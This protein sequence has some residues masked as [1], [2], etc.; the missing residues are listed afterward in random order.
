MEKHKLKIC[1][2]AEANGDHTYVQCGILRDFG[3]E[4]TLVSPN[5]GKCPDGV[6]H[7]ECSVDNPTSLMGKL[8]WLK[9]IYDGVRSVK[10]D[11]YHAHYAAELTTWMAWLLRKRPLVISCL[12]GDVLFDEQ[13]SQSALRRWMTKQALK[14]CD[15]VTVVSNFLGEAVVDFGVE[16]AKISRVIW[17][18][19][20]DIFKPLDGPSVFRVHY[21]ID[22]KAA[23]IFSPRQF[24]PFYNQHLMIE[25][26]GEVVKKVPHAVLAMST[27]N[28]DDDYREEIEQ[29]IDQLGVRDDVRFIA[30]MNQ[31][32]MTQAYNESDV[33]ISLPPSD[34]TPVS[35]MESMACGTPVVMTNLERF[36]EFFTHKESAW[37]TPLE[38][39]AIV[40]GL[41][42]VLS[43][44]ELYERMKGEAM[45]LI[46]EKADLQSQT[47]LLEE[48]S[49]K[50]VEKK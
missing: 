26:L 23:L 10:A 13:G 2:L 44:H 21:N 41:C 50:L 12:G 16:R 19:N 11:V 33:L 40:E 42:A 48:I 47:G 45:K 43:D 49:Y 14:S 29:L 3:H 27:Y 37:F 8:R 5:S 18:V 35:V 28:Q 1:V 38:K 32:E 4:V 22:P 9:R 39:N 17:G 7:I 36:K 24:K 34:G 25:A 46:C 15:Y 6:T 31:Q 30:G 20:T